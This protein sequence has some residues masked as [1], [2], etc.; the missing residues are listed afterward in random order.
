MDDILIIVLTLIFTIVAAVNQSRKKK[1]T[2]GHKIPDFWKEILQGDVVP[3][4]PVQDTSLPATPVRPPVRPVPP[5]YSAQNQNIPA[6][7]GIRNDIIT[8]MIGIQTDEQDEYLVKET[9]LEDFSLRKAFV[10]SEI[11]NPKYFSTT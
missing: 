2:G 6:E 4:R 1:E 10:F 3:E 5:V 11:I 8:G 9:V 7:E